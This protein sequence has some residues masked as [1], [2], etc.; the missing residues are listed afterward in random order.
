MRLS[1]SSSEAAAAHLSEQLR[2]RR[3]GEAFFD[4]RALDLCDIGRRVERVDVDAVRD[5]ADQAA[6][7]G[8]HGGDVEACKMALLESMFQEDEIWT[9]EVREVAVPRIQR[10]EAKE[11]CPTCFEDFA[12]GGMLRLRQCGHSFCDGCIRRY[13]ES[14]LK[15]GN[16]LIYCPEGPNC[17]KEFGQDELR[18]VLG[19][20][21]QVLCREGKPFA[22]LRFLVLRRREL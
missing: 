1:S 2:R 10:N 8:E 4:R 12:P 15:Q 7:V 18:T 14:E 22:A 17:G 16:T 9:L 13:V 3:A 11:T 5:L 19:P 21:H 6:H 20:D